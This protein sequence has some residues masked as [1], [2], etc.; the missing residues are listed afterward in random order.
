M[1]VEIASNKIPGCPIKPAHELPESSQISSFINQKY[2]VH[3]ATR[4]GAE[5]ICV[6]ILQWQFV[7][8]HI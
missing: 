7:E 2:E 3:F 6:L 8:S 1:R 4:D 5:L